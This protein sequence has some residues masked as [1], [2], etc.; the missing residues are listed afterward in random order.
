MNK[1]HTANSSGLLTSQGQSHR[2]RRTTKHNFGRPVVDT[3]LMYLSQ[4]NHKQPYIMVGPFLLVSLPLRLKKVH[5]TYKVVCL[6][7][8][9]T[10][11][12]EAKQLSTWL[13]SGI[14]TGI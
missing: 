7:I 1:Q 14:Y 5:A 13:R 10:L 8:L 11:D 3:V 6:L 12:Q 9:P 2:P 4:S